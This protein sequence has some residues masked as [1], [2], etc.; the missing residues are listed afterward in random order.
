VIVSFVNVTDGWAI[1]HEPMAPG[2]KA[3]LYVTS[4]GGRYWMTIIPNVRCC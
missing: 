3:R 2:G 1:E 4:D